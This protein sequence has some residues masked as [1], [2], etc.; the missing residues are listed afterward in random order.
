VQRL[1]TKLGKGWIGYAL[2]AFEAAG[3]KERLLAYGNACLEK[4]WL[5][6]AL[7]AFKAAASV[8]LALSK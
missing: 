7:K 8:E 5:E 3:D 1:C 6:D 4:G 2:E